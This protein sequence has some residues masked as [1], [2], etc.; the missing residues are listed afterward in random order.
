[1]S[2]SS[3]V[4]SVSPEL[5]RAI[6][7]LQETGQLS[8]ILGQSSGPMPESDA[9]GAMHDGSKRRLESSPGEGDGGFTVVDMPQ[10]S[11]KSN[12]L[13]HTPKKTVQTV[14]IPDMPDGVHSL[15]EWGRTV[16]H[17]PEMAHY[18][19]S[20]DQLVMN[21]PSDP[22]IASYLQWILTKSAKGKPVKM[23]DLRSYLNA[24]NYEKITPQVKTY[25]GSNVVRRMLPED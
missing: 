2:A 11:K 7:R 9:Q 19:M 8:A 20:Y 1:M 4:S 12:Q 3:S 15:S 18:K 10:G 22:E 14:N 6:Q 24:V 23:D 17:L 13:P 5:V 21:A 16:C 25:A